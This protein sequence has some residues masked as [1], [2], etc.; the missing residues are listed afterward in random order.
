[1]SSMECISEIWVVGKV[2]SQFPTIKSSI[3]AFPVNKVLML[4]VI[5]A[6]IQNLFDFVFRLFIDMD[7]WW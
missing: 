5:F 2:S 4:V 7:R 1:M 3:I 6:A